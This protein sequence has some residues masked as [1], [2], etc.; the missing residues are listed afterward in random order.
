MFFDCNQMQDFTTGRKNYDRIYAD[1]FLFGG[2]KMHIQ[3]T[4]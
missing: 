2:G 3:V 1:R 4:F